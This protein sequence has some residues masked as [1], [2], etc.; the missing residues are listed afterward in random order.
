MGRREGKVRRGGREVE[1]RR[2]VR[3]SCRMCR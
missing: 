3:K 1:E 2:R